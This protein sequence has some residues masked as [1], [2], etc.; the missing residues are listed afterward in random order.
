VYF[1]TCKPGQIRGRHYHK[2]KTEVFCVI[3]G[4]VEVALKT[5]EGKTNLVR[6]SVGEEYL[7]KL[8]IPVNIIH[9]VENKGD[10]DAVILAYISEKFDE[11]DPDVFYA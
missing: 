9:T 4:E 2:R 3:Q 8:F 6:L 7:N 11:K 1:F 5:L 10:K